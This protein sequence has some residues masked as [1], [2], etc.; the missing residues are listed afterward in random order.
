MRRVKHLGALAADPAVSN[1]PQFLPK[2]EVSRNGANLL[3]KAVVTPAHA[4]HIELG[5]FKFRV[6]SFNHAW[7]IQRGLL[8]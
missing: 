7:L 2:I 5:Q 1:L 6:S 8:K 3:A 4:K